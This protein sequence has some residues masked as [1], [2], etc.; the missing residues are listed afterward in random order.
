ML[1]KKYQPEAF[2]NVVGSQ[3]SVKVLKSICKNPNNSP[4]SIILFGEP[5]S[6]KTS[7]AKIFSRALNCVSNSGDCCNKCGF[8]KDSTIG[9][10]EYNCAHV[11]NVS[12]MREIQ[13]SLCHSFNGI[14]KFRTAIFDEIHMA[15]SESQSVLLSMV[16]NSPSDLFFIFCT[17]DIDQILGTLKSRS[18][19]LEFGEIDKKD[20]VTLLKEVSK[21]ENV[22][23][24]DT[25]YNRITNRSKKD[26]RTSLNLLQKAIL[27][28]EKEFIDNHM[29]LYDNV[30]DLFNYIYSNE[31]DKEIFEDK[32]DK[33][34]ANPVEY[35]R[36]DFEQVVV[37]LSDD[38]VV[39]FSQSNKILSF[40]LEYLKIQ[41]YLHSRE[42][43]NVFLNTLKRYCVG[44]TRYCPEKKTLA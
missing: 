39:D 27:I 33:I 28:G 3:F 35:I 20:V 40:V 16:E 14:G 1:T 6:G 25:L 15:S 26:I 29:C 17:T 23:F 10:Y 11:G 9:I 36:N 37:K 44:T 21:K 22:T 8:C 4:R 24:S 19:E 7:C 5:G 18:I 34:L 38:M 32:V 41:H 12:F 2:K 42:D 30:L 13:D 31:F 43:W